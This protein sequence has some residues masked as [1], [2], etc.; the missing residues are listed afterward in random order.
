VKAS[1]IMTSPV[2][3]VRSDT[4][5]KEAAR[6]L[7]EHQISALPVVDDGAGLVGIVSEADL[8]PLESRPDPRD[9]LMPLPPEPAPPRRVE[10]VMTREVYT[11]PE[12]ADVAHV[13]EVMLRANVK[14]IPIVRGDRLVGIVSRRDVI[15]LMARRD[16]VIL[17]ELEKLLAQQQ[18]LAPPVT[19]EVRNGVATIRGEGEPGAKR[20][21]E[22]LVRTIPG[23]LDVRFEDPSRDGAPGP[24]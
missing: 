18:L 19:I 16:E 6:L 5:V 17:A 15:K 20:L 24:V 7:V 13:A 9:Q 23:I 3:T 12:E 21:V 4:S 2:I 8:L 22:I 1:E 10:E 11:M 14:R